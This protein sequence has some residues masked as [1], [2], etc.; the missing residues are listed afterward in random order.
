MMNVLKRVCFWVLLVLTSS[1]GAFAQYG[2]FDKTVDWGPLGNNK[3]SGTI[4]VTGTGAS[5][6]YEFQGNGN[7][8]WNTEDEGFYIYKEVEG[9]WM[10]Q[11]ALAW[12]DPGPDANSKIGLMFREKPTAGTSR[13]Y[14]VDLRGN[15]L[16][17][18]THAQWRPLEGANALDS[19]IFEDINSFDQLEANADGFLWLRVIRFASSN[20]FVSQW[21]R[22]GVTWTNG[23][24]IQLDNWAAKSGLGIAITSHTDDD[25]LVWAEAKDVQLTKIPFEASRS[26]AAEDFN[27]GSPVSGVKVTLNV[28]AGSTPNVTVKENPPAGWAISNIQ[29]SAGTAQVN[30]GSIV[31]TINGA[32]GNPTLTYDVTPPGDASSGEWTGSFSGE[33]ID[34]SMQ[35][36]ILT[37]SNKISVYF[38]GNTEAN[39]QRNT[40]Y[41]D[42]LGDGLN[43]PDENGNPVFIPGLKYQ[44]EFI[45]HDVDDPAVAVNFDLVITHEAVSSNA[46]ARYVDLPIPYLVIEQVLYAGRSDREGSIW[47]A[48]ANQVSTSNDFDFVV[49]DNTH[50]IT[51]IYEPDQIVTV[52]R[53]PA[54]QIGGI[55]YDALAPAATPLMLSA[56][57]ARVTLAVAEKGATGLVGDAGLTPPP[58]SDPLPERRAI[59]GMH[60]ACQAFDL[61][62]AGGLDNIALTPEGA[63]LFQ[64]VVQ[65]MVGLEPTADG[66][67][68]GVGVMEW[69]LY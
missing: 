59:L 29:A 2:V 52:T 34:F 45:S 18:E 19:T 60:E 25:L 35:P 43:I 68:A 69:A 63:I 11:G 51:K 49:D 7:D 58:G 41:L 16:G 48:P 54:G 4:S 40:I 55:N 6:S 39:A 17:D 62:I 38:I 42:L 22:D 67:E 44:A 12:I 47:F 26:I 64:R 23:H 46:A 3:V 33:G 57:F 53:N 31:W 56:D 27:P 61:G 66:T 1:G 65:W 21:S 15:G 20:R 14:W 50:P 5:A 13:Y 36:N 32:S 9:S 37:S 10:L 8:I 30:G 28:A 24:S